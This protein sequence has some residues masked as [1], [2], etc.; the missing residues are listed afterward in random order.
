M[1][2]SYMLLSDFV[3]LFTEAHE[4]EV[5]LNV[6]RTTT[7]SLRE[8]I[9]L[10]KSE[11]EKAAKTFQESLSKEKELS[12][13]CR[14]QVC[15]PKMIIDIRPDSKRQERELHLTHGSLNDLRS[16]AEQHQRKVQELEEQIQSDDRLERMEDS[17]KNTQERADELDFQL[18]KLKQVSYL[19]LAECSKKKL[20]NGS[21]LIQL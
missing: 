15:L 19:S 21:R 11:A 18:S 4:K 17:L 5:L 14:E 7:K 1:I 9:D 3:S 16:Q 6:E 8:E 10:L 13:K 20:T 12:D 2:L